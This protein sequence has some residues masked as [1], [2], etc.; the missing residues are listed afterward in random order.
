MHPALLGGL[1]L[2]IA[3]T[4]SSAMAQSNVT[5]YGLLDTAMVST[6]GGPDGSEF[7]IDSGVSNGSRIGF[8]GREDLGNG[9]SAIFQLEAGILLDSGASDQNGTL[10]GRQ[11]FMGL[12]GKMGTLT[13]GRQYTPIYHTLTSVDP[14]NNNYGGAAGQLMSGAK[15]GTRM[16]NTVM[17]VSPEIS[18]LTGQLAY[19]AGEVPG[20][21]AKSR[22]LGASLTYKAGPLLLRGG[23]NRTNNVTAT[24][25]AR[26]VLLVGEY[27]FGPLTAGFGYGTNRGQRGIDS[28]D[29]I[30][31]LTVP[32]GGAHTLMA[33][34]IHKSDRANTNMGA[35]QVA[36]AYTYYLTKRTNVYVAYSKLSN[37]RFTTSK[38][39]EGDRE[40]DVGIKHLF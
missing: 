32:L 6:R 27:D 7:K 25:S 11:A 18:G 37:I 33:T 39:G 2:A 28:R 19:G 23:Y 20:D 30:A 4:S 31:A 9:L 40:L 22:Q 1:A 36:A 3:S 17:Y 38:F 34:L 10:F 5:I 24:D 8:R 35:N 14:F 26:N 21:S 16:N 15:A 13:I 29:Y 12:K